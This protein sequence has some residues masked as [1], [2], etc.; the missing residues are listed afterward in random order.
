M[1]G[2]RDTFLLATVQNRRMPAKRVAIPLPKRSHAAIGYRPPAP[3][4]IVPIDQK[5][6]A[7]QPQTGPIRRDRSSLRI[8]PSVPG[9]KQSAKTIVAILGLVCPGWD[10]ERIPHPRQSQTKQRAPRHLASVPH[11]HS[12]AISPILQANEWHITDL[13]SAPGPEI[14]QPAPQRQRSATTGTT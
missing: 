13:R 10:R 1:T 11:L 2:P 8:A 5:P 12:P 9:D 7:N 14:C 4:T 6:V 3:E